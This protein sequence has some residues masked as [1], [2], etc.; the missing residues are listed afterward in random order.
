M[1]VG[2]S[3]HGARSFCRELF[4]SHA[5][6]RECCSF[7]EEAPQGPLAAIKAAF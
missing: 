5:T 2:R 7:S 6:S 3:A 1:V 4:L